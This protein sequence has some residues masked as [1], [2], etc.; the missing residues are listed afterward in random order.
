MNPKLTVEIV[1]SDWLV[2]IL[3]DPI[4]KTKL[5]KNNE[6]FYFENGFSYSIK[7]NVPDF[8][9]KLNQFE[10]DWQKGQDQYEQSMIKYLNNGEANLNYYVEEQRK[11]APM[12]M[13]LQLEGRVLDVGGNLGAIRKYMA[14]T[15]EFCS[16]DPF[17]EVYK[18][19]E[20]RISL[21]EHYPMHLPLNFVAGFAEFLPFQKSTFDTVNMRSC[22]DHFF[23][24]TL[25]LLE[26]YRVLRENGKL[27]IGMT[28]KV[29]SISNTVKETARKVLNLVTDKF[30]DNHLFHPTKEELV[31][32]CSKCGFILEDEI[33]QSENVWYASFRKKSD[34]LLKIT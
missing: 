33:W 28:V 30:K 25:S 5:K 15:Q 22:I 11:D 23:N 7:D 26:A 10:S 1:Q 21:H 31:M 13:K 29:N 16:I 4:S 34:E 19:A 17:I 14:A 9:I 24:P 8:R 2:E 3:A 20:G 6:G 32:L 12:Y 27:I 18:L